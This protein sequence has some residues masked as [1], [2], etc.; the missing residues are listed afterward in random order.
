[1]LWIVQCPIV[2]SFHTFRPDQSQVLSWSAWIN[3]FLHRHIHRLLV[4]RLDAWPSDPL[5]ASP[6][7]PSRPQKTLSLSRLISCTLNSK[8]CQ[9]IRSSSILH[10]DDLP[11]LLTNWPA[12]FHIVVIFISTILPSFHHHL[13]SSPHYH[14]NLGNPCL[15]FYHSLAAGSRVHLLQFSGNISENFLASL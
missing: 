10:H 5:P 3:V 13:H 2:Y 15:R 9:C 6:S 8:L 11:H 7:H 12:H 14:Q 4:S 1:M